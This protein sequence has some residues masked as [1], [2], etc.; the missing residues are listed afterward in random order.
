MERPA[1]FNSQC[2]RCALPM[3]M[4]VSIEPFAGQPGLHAYVCL[5]CRRAQHAQPSRRICPSQ[6]KVLSHNG[7][8]K[9]QPKEEDVQELTNWQT[10]GDESLTKIETELSVT[11]SRSRSR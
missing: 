11:K 7:K 4:V 8:S 1:P 10:C 9:M 5:K 3:E 2:G 6:P